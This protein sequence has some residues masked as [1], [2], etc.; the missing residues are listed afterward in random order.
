MRIVGPQMACTGTLIADDLVLTAHH[1]VVRRGPNGEF[2]RA[3]LTGD[4]LDVELGG[5]YLAWGSVGVRAIVAPPCGEAGGGGDVAVLV[6]ERKLV[7]LATMRPRLDKPPKIGEALEPVGFG[8]CAMSPDAIRRKPR[9]GGN[10]RALS[11][12]TLALE[13]SI[14]PGD[15]GGPLLAKGG[16][17]V[18]GVIS[19]SAIDGD[20]RTRELSIA[21]RLDAFRLVFAHARAIADGTSPS[22]LPP[23]DCN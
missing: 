19:L 1:C 16:H 7:G 5:D 3:L 12:D 21:A 11:G 20:D 23:L 18:V 4:A 22:D 8:R 9:S 17:D 13:A 2:T 14:C 6:L 10:V 15:S